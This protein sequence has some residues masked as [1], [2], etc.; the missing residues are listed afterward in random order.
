LA[1]GRHKV[2]RR[3]RR[4]RESLGDALVELIREKPFAAIT[5]QEVLDRANVGR[6]T[7]YTHYRDKDDLFLS[8]VD[9]FFAGMATLLSRRGDTSNRIAPGRELFAHIADVR[10]FY[11]ALVTSGKIHDV[12]EIGQGHLTRGIE[13]RLREMPRAQDLRAPARAATSAALAG[14]LLSLLTWWI[15]RGMPGTPA[16][17]DD[18]YHR[19]AWSGIAARPG[20]QNR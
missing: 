11:A 20:P 12:L 10:D 9:D 4:T 1:A 8:D 14:A 2:D 17:M 15:D 7:F 16:E 6:S 19:L 13:L 5:V 18:L 3:V